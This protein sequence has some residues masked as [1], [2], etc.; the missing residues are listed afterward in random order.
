MSP[1]PDNA[2]PGAGHSAWSPARAPL[3]AVLPLG[4]GL[5]ALAALVA[6][7]TRR[8]DIHPDLLF[9]DV[10]DFA[11]HVKYPQPYIGLLS[12]LGLVFWFSGGSF[13]LLAALIVADSR[14]VRGHAAHLLTWGAAVFVLGLDDMLL[15]HEHK[16]VV[17][18]GLPEP[19]SIG[20]YLVGFLLLVGATWRELRAHEF[21]LF[22]TFTLL[23]LGSELVDVFRPDGEARLLE[24]RPV[25]TVL[26]EGLKLLGQI[27][28]WTYCLRLSVSALL[29]HRDAGGGG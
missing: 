5:L 4:L 15:L 11:D 13:C 29:D 14:D 22:A 19:A 18:L 6:F 26:E 3:L 10:S 28:L 8:P 17:Y 25:Y 9:T 23:L 12:Q 2:S 20:L 27:A 16:F 21:P 1:T 7:L 24:T